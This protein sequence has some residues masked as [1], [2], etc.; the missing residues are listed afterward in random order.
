MIKKEM[1]GLRFGRL[2]VVSEAGRDVKTRRIVYSCVCDCGNSKLADGIYLRNGKVKSCGCLVRDSIKER[3]QKHDSGFKKLLRGYKDSARRRGY[4]FGLSEDQFRELT[5][6]NCHYCGE[7]PMKISIK[8]SQ[9]GIYRYNGIDRKDNTVGYVYNNC[10][11]CCED[12]NFLKTS[13]DYDTFI[14]M[15]SK[16]YQNLNKL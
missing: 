14:D 8:C 12:C 15:V 13:L 3:S 11:T 1:V 5:S 4:S 9:V 16:I 6:G 7:S 10:V 2:L